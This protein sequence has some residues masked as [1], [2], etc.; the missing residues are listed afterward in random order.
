[1][2]FIKYLISPWY[3]WNAV[4]V[5]LNSNQ[6]ISSVPDQQH[7]WK[8]L[9]HMNWNCI[10]M[11]CKLSSKRDIINTYP[12]WSSMRRVY[13]HHPSVYIVHTSCQAQNLLMPWRILMILGMN[14]ADNLRVQSSKLNFRIYWPENFK[15]IIFI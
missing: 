8:M 5:M 7:I 15:I 11:N 14:V 2:T 1:M 12:K 10:G 9:S 13:C 3:C 4:K 6:S